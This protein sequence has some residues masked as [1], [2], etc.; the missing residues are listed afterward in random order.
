M[1]ENGRLEELLHRHRGIGLMLLCALMVVIGSLQMDKAAIETGSEDVAKELPLD[2]M[3]AGTGEKETIFTGTFVGEDLDVQEVLAILKNYHV[4]FR[5]VLH[6]E[7]K[8]GYPVRWFIEYL[9]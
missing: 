9:E 5:M 1:K 2:I 3:P 6:E 7:K 4:Q 8:E